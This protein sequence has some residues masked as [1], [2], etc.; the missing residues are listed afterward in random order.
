MQKLQTHGDKSFF[1]PFMTGAG[2][3]GVICRIFLSLPVNIFI[4]LAFC[5]SASAVLFPAGLFTAHGCASLEGFRLFCNP[6]FK[7]SYSR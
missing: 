7:L 5:P 2:C 1:S 6:L 4:S 3:A